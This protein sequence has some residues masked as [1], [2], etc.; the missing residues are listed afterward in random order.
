MGKRERK[1]EVIKKYIKNVAGT[2]PAYSYGNIPRN[3]ANNACSS[4][5]GSIQYDDIIGLIDITVLGSGKKG[6]LFTLQKVYFDNG[7]LDKQGSISYKYIYEKGAVPPDVCGSSYNNQALVEV[8]SELARIEG[9]NFESKMNNINSSIDS[10]NHG[11][12]TIVDTISKGA[13]L[14]DS[15]LNIFGSDSTEESNDVID[16]EAVEAHPLLEQTES[17]EESDDLIET[18]EAYRDFL[19]DYIEQ[20]DENIVDVDMSDL[21][22]TVAHFMELCTWAA[23]SGNDLKWYR[24]LADDIDDE[25]EEIFSTMHQMAGE[26]DQLISEEA[27]TTGHA[28]DEKLQRAFK[29]F[30]IKVRR[31]YDLLKSDFDGDQEA[32]K[33]KI[34][35]DVQSAAKVMRKKACMRQ[36]LI[37][38]ILE[39]AYDEMDD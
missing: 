27:G 11:V 23:F 19:E 29:Q 10:I 3:L 1:I 26:I 18:A 21:P 4:Y 6:M 37:N 22:E 9:E 14:L 15:I 30:H 8:L 39:R 35:N 5:A 13:D 12:N 36:N 2:W 31:Q 24:K 25:T 34:F 32:D 28:E 20:L 16:V 7:L 17:S 33:E 38:E